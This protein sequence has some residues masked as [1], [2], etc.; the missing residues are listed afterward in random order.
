MNGMSPRTE[1][2]WANVRQSVEIRKA[3]ALA[4]VERFIRDNQYTLKEAL[5]VVSEAE[6]MAAFARQLSTLQR[7]RE[8]ERK[9]RAQERKI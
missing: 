5:E 9:M 8:Q 7:I 6:L 4:N 3:N 2:R 1:R